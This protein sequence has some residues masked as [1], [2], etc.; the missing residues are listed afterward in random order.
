MMEH[1]TTKTAKDETTEKSEVARSDWPSPRRFFDWLG[2]PAFGDRL[3]SFGFFDEHMLRTE[4]RGDLEKALGD[5]HRLLGLEAQEFRIEHGDACIRQ[6]P[7]RLTQERP[8]TQDVVRRDAHARRGRHP[9]ADGPEARGRRHRDEI[10]RRRVQ[11]RQVRERDLPA[12]ATLPEEQLAGVEPR[13]RRE[14]ERLDVDTLVVAVKATRHR[15]RRQ[16]AREQPEAIGDGAVLAE[17]RR[18]GEPD[19]EAR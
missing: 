14:R 16:R 7:Q 8:L 15:L 4:P 3:E 9:D 18:V 17:V 13:L 10:R 12:N 6:A 5:A 2:W 19:D 1:K 11:H